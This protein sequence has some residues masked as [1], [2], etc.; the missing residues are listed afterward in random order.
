MRRIAFISL[1]FAFVH[2]FSILGSG[3]MSLD[4]EKASFIENST[5]SPGY[6]V[7]VTFPTHYP[8]KK[9]SIFKRRYDDWMTGC[10]KEWSKIDC[11][12]TERSRMEMS[13]TQTKSHH[14]YTKVGFQ[15]MKVPEAIF[16]EIRE[17]FDANKANEKVEMVSRGYTYVNVWEAPTTM[18]SFEDKRFRGGWD[19]KERVW[20]ALNPVLS[21]WI[22][23]KEIVPTSLYGIRIYKRGAYLATRKLNYKFLFFYR[24]IIMTIFCLYIYI[25]RCGSNAAGYL[26]HYSSSP[27]C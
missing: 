25:Y 15:K 26:V 11:E 9:D 16:K 2:G 20:N 1:L 10:A 14:N 21:A 27:R 4:E 24:M 17:F 5:P 23:G 22:G 19:L 6:G 12:A 3:K 18:V 8:L 7:D 13:R